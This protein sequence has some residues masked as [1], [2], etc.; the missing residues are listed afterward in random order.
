LAVSVS[1]CTG[2]LLIVGGEVFF[3]GGAGPALTTPVWAD[4]AVPVPSWF[5]AV[6]CTRGV[7]P[8]SSLLTV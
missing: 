8:T 2:L 5:F 7:E 4:W 6:I 3:G 1:P